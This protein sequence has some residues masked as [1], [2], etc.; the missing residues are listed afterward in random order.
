MRSTHLPRLAPTC[1]NA[2]CSGSLCIRNLTNIPPSPLHRTPQTPSPSHFHRHP[3]PSSPRSLDSVLPPSPPSPTAPRSRSYSAP[4]SVDAAAAATATSPDNPAY[5]CVSAAIRAGYNS[6]HA[7]SPIHG[8]CR[9]RGC[10]RRAG[11]GG[12]AEHRR[13]RTCTRAVRPSAFLFLLLLACERGREEVVAYLGVGVAPRGVG[14]G[15][16]AGVGG[17]RGRGGRSRGLFD[18]LAGG[19]DY[20][21][22]GVWGAR[23]G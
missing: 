9:N 6:A 21:D 3:P 23:G 5:N 19:P 18:H 14:A 2:N 10:G 12:D 15:V 7:R 17:G 13:T 8:V 1:P 22:G 16:G 20:A 4:P 11:V